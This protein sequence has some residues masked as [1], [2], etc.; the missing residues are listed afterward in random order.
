MTPGYKTTEHWQAVATQ[1]LTALTIFGVISMDDAASLGKAAAASVAALGM[2]AVN[3]TV[4]VQ[5]IRSRTTLKS[6]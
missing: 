6:K 3:G 2:L 1:V 4:L 5:Y